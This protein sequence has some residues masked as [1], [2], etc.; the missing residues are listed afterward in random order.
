VAHAGLDRRPYESGSS[1]HRPRRISQVGNR[2]QRA[3]L[4]MPA[5][6]ALH[7]EPN[8]K[9]FCDKLV[10]AGKKP[11]QAGVAVMRKLLHAI[12]GMLKHDRDF[13][14][15]KLFKLPEKAT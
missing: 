14:G 7:H 6:V 11:M 3:A 12:R 13:D 9:A 8:A 5:L 1:V 15:N 4:H 2:H 10:A